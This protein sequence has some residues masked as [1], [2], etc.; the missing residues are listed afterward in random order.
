M[1][2]LVK[3]DIR[4]NFSNRFSDSLV[5]FLFTPICALFISQSLMGLLIFY[6]PALMAIY[7]SIP[8][9]EKSL[10]KRYNILIQSLPIKRWEYVLSK[11]ISI[12]I[13]YIIIIVYVL[14]I[15]K[16]LGFFG[17]NHLEYIT[18]KDIKESFVISLATFALLLPITF[19]FFNKFRIFMTIF[20]LSMIAQNYEYEEYGWFLSKLIQT[21]K[22]G[23]ILIIILIYGVSI[24]ISIWAYNE[25]DLT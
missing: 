4:V 6:I 12:I 9:D 1:L 23:S 22:E 15:L 24:G 5:L 11:Y 19:M 18:F 3:K 10:S 20:S 7:R 21:L 17:F 2:R 8:M 13:N 16:I 25:K 14:L